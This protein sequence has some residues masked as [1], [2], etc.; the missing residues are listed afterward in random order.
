MTPPRITLRRAGEHD[1]DLLFEWRND[2]DAVRFSVS[3]QPVTREDHERWFAMRRDDPS[4]HLWIA[5]EH[6]IPVAQ[7]RVDVVPPAGVVS[8]AVAV[9]HRGRGLGS[10]V[11]RA[12]VSEIAEDDRVRVLRALVHPDNAHSI[13]AFERAGFHRSGDIE[14]G[15]NVLLRTVGS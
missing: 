8:V 14:G 1:A 12:M 3:G 7:V 13:R 9:S 6:G 10:E 4:V 5:D 2:P 11:L 15:F